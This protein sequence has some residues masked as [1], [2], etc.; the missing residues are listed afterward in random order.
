MQP[1]LE[2]DGCLPSGI[3]EELLLSWLLYHTGWA[4]PVAQIPSVRQEVLGRRKRSLE[5][6]GEEASRKNGDF[7]VRLSSPVPSDY[8]SPPS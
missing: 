2:C 1:I 3:G 5:T 7:V 4:I 6:K 8:S